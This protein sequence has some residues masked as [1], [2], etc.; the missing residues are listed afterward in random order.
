MLRRK[1]QRSGQRHLQVILL[2]L[3]GY[4]A[5]CLQKLFCLLQELLEEVLLRRRRLLKVELHDLVCRILSLICPAEAVLP[6]EGASGGSDVAL[7]SPPVLAP[8][9]GTEAALRRLVALRKAYFIEDKSELMAA[10]AAA[11]VH[12]GFAV[13]GCAA[14]VRGVGASGQPGGFSAG[15]F[16]ARRLFDSCPYVAKRASLE[17]KKSRRT[18]AIAK[19][20]PALMPSLDTLTKPG[21]GELLC[22]WIVPF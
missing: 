6:S 5:N 12:R 9:A 13:S 16:V 19:V 11:A 22:L 20:L 21:K 10:H 2:Y 7:P 17:N 14:P 15:A 18:V 8:Q 4:V 1:M 3:G